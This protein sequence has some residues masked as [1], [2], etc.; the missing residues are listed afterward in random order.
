LRHRIR[1]FGLDPSRREE[2]MTSFVNIEHPTEHAGV[3]RAER[4]AR[5]VSAVVR[6][7]DGARGAAT[8]LLAA[9]V[10]ALLVVANQVIDTWSEG[11]LLVAWIVMWTVA[12]AALALL[13]APARR[14]ARGLRAHAAARRAAAADR[15]LID[16]AR[17]DA[18]IIAEISRAMSASAMR[19]VRYY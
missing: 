5:A 13:A 18:R 12:F 15:D 7:F 6:N 16:A 17:T 8:L 14:V 10:S 11:H 2:T 19:D 9:V 4:A 1:H 3:V